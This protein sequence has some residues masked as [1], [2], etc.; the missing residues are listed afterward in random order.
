MHAEQFDACHSVPRKACPVGS[1]GVNTWHVSFFLPHTTP[2]I[3][4]VG[5]IP[6][7]SRRHGFEFWT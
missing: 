1:V 4:I 2:A 6:V 3:G 7:I 5:L